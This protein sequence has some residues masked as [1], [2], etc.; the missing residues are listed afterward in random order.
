MEVLC[1]LREVEVEVEMRR[2]RQNYS[3]PSRNANSGSG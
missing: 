1:I 3:V 2:G